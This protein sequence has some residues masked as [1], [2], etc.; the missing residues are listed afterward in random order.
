MRNFLLLLFIIGLAAMS[1]TGCNRSMTKPVMD[2]VMTPVTEMPTTEDPEAFTMAFVQAAVELYKMAGPEAVL[3]TYND[4]ASVNGQWYVFIAGE[5]DALVAH[6]VIPELL[7]TPLNDIV[8]SDGYLAGQAVAMATEEGDWI[9]Y[10]WPNP[11]NGKLELKRTWAIRYGGYLFGSGYYKPWNPDPSTLRPVPKDDP[12]AYTVSLVH[13]AIARYEFAG[14]EA[15][16]AHYN[17]PANIDGQWYLLM[18]DSNDLIV[19]HPLS[20]ELI[21]MDA[22][23]TFPPIGAAI[24]KATGAGHWVEYT[25]PNPESGEVEHKHTWAIRH[26]GYVFATGYYVPLPEGGEPAVAGTLISPVN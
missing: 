8:G 24:V 10:L 23:E 12:R 14:A 4:P 15:T 1:V 22:N 6:P 18:S 5:N 9:D 2:D 16:A 17:D 21:G 7:G 19:V 11:E 26:D 13:E 25:W 20:P 3:A